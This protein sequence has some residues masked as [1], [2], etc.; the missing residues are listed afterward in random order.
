MNFKVIPNDDAG[1]WELH[2]DHG[3]LCHLESE[4][5]AES[6]AHCVNTHDEL[7]AALERLT[8]KVERANTIQHSG[9][10]VLPEDWS[11]LYQ[12]TNESRGTLEKIQS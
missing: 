7:V 2:D 5:T 6:L 10:S 8:E 1:C 12:L 9:G 4:S 3:Y 11:E